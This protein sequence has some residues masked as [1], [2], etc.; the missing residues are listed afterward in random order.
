M[1]NKQGY[2]CY[3]NSSKDCLTMREST[4]VSIHAHACCLAS[5]YNLKMEAVLFSSVLIRFDNMSTW[6]A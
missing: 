5:L 3:D 6:K 4:L 2:Y 1:S